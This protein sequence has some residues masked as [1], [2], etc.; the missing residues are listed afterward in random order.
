MLLKELGKYSKAPDKTNDN[1]LDNKRPNDYAGSGCDSA[2]V[3]DLIASNMEKDDFAD[4]L[5]AQLD[6]QVAAKDSQINKLKAEIDTLH[7][8]AVLSNNQTK[9]VV[10]YSKAVKKDDRKKGVGNFLLKAVV[11]GEAAYII[12]KSIH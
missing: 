7:K 8:V 6:I 10:D 9:K 4:S 3:A 5:R 12:I 2:L 11:I 1:N